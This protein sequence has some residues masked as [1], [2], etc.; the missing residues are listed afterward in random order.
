M[1]ACAVGATASG[2]TAIAALVSSTAASLFIA[3]TSFCLPGPPLLSRAQFQEL[4]RFRWF[5]IER[6]LGVLRE[7]T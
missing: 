2:A 4:S 5:G 3:H 7:Y 6:P 1:S